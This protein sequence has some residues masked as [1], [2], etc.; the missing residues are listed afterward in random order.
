MSA[1]AAPSA[2]PLNA[3]KV[4][5]DLHYIYVELPSKPGAPI[6][7]MSYPRSGKGLDS[8]LGLIYGHADTSGKPELFRPGRKFTPQ[9][10]Q[11]EAIL[12]QRG[13]LK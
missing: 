8:L 9:V 4:W 5:A 1:T 12:R 3:L 7:V 10:A 11:A 2:A 6:H 13:M